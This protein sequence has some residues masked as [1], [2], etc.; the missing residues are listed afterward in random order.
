M[1][2]SFNSG[3]LVVPENSTSRIV[4][5]FFYDTD[6][7]GLIARNIKWLDIL[8]LEITEVDEDTESF[9][10]GFWENFEKQAVLDSVFKYPLPEDFQFEKLV[11]LNRFV[12]LISS[13]STIETDITRFLSEEENQFLLKMAFF[14]SEVHSEKECDWQTEAERKSIRPDF[15]ITEPNGYSNIIE[16]KLP[17]LRASAVVGQTNR[18]AFSAQINSYI[19][20]TNVYEEYFEDPNNRAYV[21]EKYGLN[22]RYP[23]RV[24]VVGRRWMFDTHDWKRIQ[25]DYRN[26]TIRTFDDLIDGVLAQLYS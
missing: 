9:K 2:M 12:E 16:F 22:V 8:P 23:D 17:G 18:E 20:Q 4:N 7:K 15:F 6:A 26:I 1:V 25:R 13:E 5:S 10:L 3:G 11:Q 21:K 24:L 14:G 19:A